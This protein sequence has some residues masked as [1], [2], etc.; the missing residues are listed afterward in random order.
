M[1]CETLHPLHLYTPY[2][3]LQNYLNC[4]SA[5]ADS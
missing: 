2:D 1:Q 4:G 5:I 3:K